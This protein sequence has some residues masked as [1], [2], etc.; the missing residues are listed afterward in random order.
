MAKILVVD[1]EPK[2]TSL[3]CGALED[4]GH[5]VE[6]TVDPAEALKLIEQHTFDV[7]ITDMSMPGVSGMKVLE[8]ARAAEA[9]TE[10]I[11]MTA[12]A[13]AETAVEAMK[14]GAADYLIKP[15]SL[16]E[17]VLQVQRLAARQK[18]ASLAE[19]FQKVDRERSSVEFIGSSPATERV[20][21]LIRQVAAADATVLLTGKSGTG[22]EVAARMIHDLSNRREHPFIAINCA[23]V[24]ET[25]LESEMFG[26]EK[27]AFTGAIARKQG[28]FE[29]ADSGSIFLDE[30]AEMSPEM[31]TK[32]LRV[33]EERQLVRVGGVDT[34]SF[35][36]RVL[37][38]TNRD[39]KEEIAAGAFREDLFFRL[40]VFPIDLP[41]LHERGEDV[42][43]LSEHFLKQQSYRHI[44][45]TPDI[46]DLFLR[47]DW[48][49]NIRELRNVLERAT[50][51]AGGEALTAEDFSL[52]VNTDPLTTDQIRGG[53]KGGLESAEK[54]MILEALEQAGGNKTE[55]ARLLKIS[56]RRL[57]SR[58]KIHGL[59][60]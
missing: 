17:L 18:V 2:M 49:G 24:T 15:F 28:R 60:P 4:E 29:L 55:A 10:V 12:Y 16:D 20:K 50:I 39:L 11:M 1:D 37:A 47:Y 42:L 58:M 59:K 33:L 5:A 14:K 43:A 25:L 40:N 30:I 36:V 26:H 53:S 44:E 8:K 3:I 34:V 19:H 7:V 13:T 52:D 9:G 32:L 46:R 27:G 48:P 31:Q 38:A 54:E 45:L 22:K 57:Y 41:P 6:T 35:D 21:K 56:R 51:L 23:A